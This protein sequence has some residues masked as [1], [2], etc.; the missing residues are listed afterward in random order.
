MPSVIAVSPLNT[1]NRI[2]NKHKNKILKKNETRNIIL[3]SLNQINLYRKR[4]KDLC[5]LP[6]LIKLKNMIGK[7]LVLNEANRFL[8]MQDFSEK[9]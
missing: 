5:Y 6:S 8:K 4:K 3:T 1:I 2:L 7:C 9:G